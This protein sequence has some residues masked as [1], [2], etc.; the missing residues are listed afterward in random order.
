M[1]VK[2]SKCS[3][4]IT[5][6]DIIESSRGRLSH[7]DCKRPGTLTVE[8][9]ALIFIYCSDHAVARCLSCDVSLRFTELGADVLGGRT[10]MCPR[11]R[12]DLTENVRAHLYRCATVPAEVRLAAQAVRETAMRLVKQSHQLVDGADGLFREAETALFASQQALRA[13]MSRKAAS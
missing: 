13:A 4:P 6:T 2:C 5:L 3:R 8:E 11:C 12:K 10:N 9:R 7:V 1:Q